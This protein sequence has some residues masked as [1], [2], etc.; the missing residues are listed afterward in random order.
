MG[1][2]SVGGV[3]MDGLHPIIAQALAAHAPKPSV[4]EA[5]L[6]I[7]R[8]NHRVSELERALRSA[9][10]DRD[11]LVEAINQR[12]R[13]EAELRAIIRDLQDWVS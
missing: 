12:A 3:I 4:E 11:Q 13:I 6:E 1:S 10:E 7:I 5:Q 2:H 8:L 9:N